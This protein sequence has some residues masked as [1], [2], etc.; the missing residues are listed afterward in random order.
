MKS[1][2]FVLSLGCFLPVFSQDMQSND[3]PASYEERPSLGFY[4]E[5]STISSIDASL[6]LKNKVTGDSLSRYSVK[7]SKNDVKISPMMGVAGHLPFIPSVFKYW[8]NVSGVVGGQN[9]EYTFTDSVGTEKKVSSFNFVIQGGPELGI[10]VWTS[11]ESQQMFK[12]FGFSHVSLQPTF[13]AKSF[14]FKN[15]LALGW[16]WGTGARYAVDRLSI[17]GGVKNTPQLLWKPGFNE[18]AE[19]A[20]GTSS[21]NKLRVLYSQEWI[22]Y[23]TLEY[24]LY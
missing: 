19:K 5:L 20:Q 16:A 24:S 13:H 17:S 1:A 14:E 7:D 10:P 8:V 21:E 22:P 9:T 2:L 15:S 3:Q 11:V 6:Q 4:G 12:V 18:S 23:I